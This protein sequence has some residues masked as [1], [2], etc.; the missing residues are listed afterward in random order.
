MKVYYL[1]RHGLAG[2]VKIL[3]TQ[4]GIDVSIKDKFMRP[5]LAWAMEQQHIKSEYK[6]IVEL[7]EEHTGQDEMDRSVWVDGSF[8]IKAVE[9]GKQIK[10]HFGWHKNMLQV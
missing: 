4:P 6:E 10:F 9:G 7:L 5:A 8:Q 2:I 1:Y 3:L